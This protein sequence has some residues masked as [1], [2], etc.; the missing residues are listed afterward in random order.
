MLDKMKNLGPK[1]TIE[2]WS[3]LSMNQRPNMRASTCSQI[4]FD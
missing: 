4:Y 1:Q 2:L 3:V